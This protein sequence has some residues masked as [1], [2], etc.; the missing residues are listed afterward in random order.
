MCKNF[1]CNILNLLHICYSFLQVYDH[2][3]DTYVYIKYI[4]YMLQQCKIRAQLH[5]LWLSHNL[6]M[7]TEPVYIYVQWTLSIYICM[8][9]VVQ[10]VPIVCRYIK[11]IMYE[12]YGSL[13]FYE[14]SSKVCIS[15]KSIYI[16]I[17]IVN[18]ICS[19]AKNF[20]CVLRYF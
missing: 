11:I 2:N 13:Q 14:F 15:Q 9:M 16:Y 12:P 19:V 4:L 10:Y 8:W 6:P 3:V 18:I 17:Y 20:W 7:N 1:F 5:H